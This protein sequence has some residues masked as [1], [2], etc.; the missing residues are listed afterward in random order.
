M[1]TNHKLSEGKR[2]YSM[3]LLGWNILISKKLLTQEYTVDSNMALK[4][5]MM[6]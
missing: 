6:T 2:L 1:L 4:M 5:K 3:R